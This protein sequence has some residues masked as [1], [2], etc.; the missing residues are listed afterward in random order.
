MKTKLIQIGNSMGIR[1]PKTIISECG[2]GNELELQVK[3]GALIV[4]P[5]AESRLGWKEIMQD[6]MLHN[7]IKAE[8]EW[9]W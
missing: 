3:Q 1:L 6:E 8:G 5:V 2:F 7:T 9:E 4:T